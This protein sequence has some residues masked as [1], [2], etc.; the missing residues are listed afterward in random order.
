ML[1]N[2]TYVNYLFKKNLFGVKGLQEIGTAKPFKP[3]GHVIL[4]V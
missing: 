2:I 3:G 4:T 1:F